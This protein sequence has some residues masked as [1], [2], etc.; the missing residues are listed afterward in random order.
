MPS[1]IASTEVTA[2]GAGAH[3][4]GIV[5][6]PAH[7]A[8]AGAAPSAAP[9]ASISASSP[10]PVDDPCS[11]EVVRRDLHAHPIP[12]Q[13]PDAEAA[14]LARDMAEDDMAVVEL[15]L[16]MAFGRASMTSPSNSTFSSFGN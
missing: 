10:M 9:I 11:V 3:D 14:H 1:T 6:E 15:T 13:D 5:A 12:R 16:N 8:R 2:S 7:D 4:R